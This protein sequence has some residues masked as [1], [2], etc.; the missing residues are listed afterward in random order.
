MIEKKKKKKVFT[1]VFILLSFFSSFEKHIEKI[2]LHELN[3]E[4]IVSCS[5]KKKNHCTTRLRF[6]TVLL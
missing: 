2:N 3:L 5:P 4:Q 1:E 6:P